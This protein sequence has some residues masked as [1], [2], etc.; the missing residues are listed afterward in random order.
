M[1]FVLIGDLFHFSRSYMTL[2]FFIPY[3]VVIKLATSGEP[4]IPPPTP[5][6][7]QKKTLCFENRMKRWKKDISEMGREEKKTQK[8]SLSRVEPKYL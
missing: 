5:T 3:K 1:V 8:D 7:T 2:F 6:P 4:S